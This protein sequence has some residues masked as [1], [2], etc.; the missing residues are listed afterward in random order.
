MQEENATGFVREDLLERLRNLTESQSD[1][2][3]AELAYR[4]AREA[5]ERALEEARSLRLAAI[6][7]VRTTREREQASLLESLKALRQSTEAQIETL[8]RTAEIEAD[9]LRSSAQ[10]TASTTVEEANREAASIRAEAAAIRTAAEGRAQEVVRLEAEFNALL[11]Q[12][13]ERLGMAEKP[14]AG[15]W[16]RITR[17]HKN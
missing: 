2:T 14:A 15:W 8:L 11:A 17:S 9:R 10:H 6:E 12:V 5:L 4:R 16:A 3:L 13:G 7:D 1:A